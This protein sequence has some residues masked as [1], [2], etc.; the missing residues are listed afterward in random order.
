EDEAGRVK[1]AW[2]LKADEVF[3]TSYIRVFLDKVGR[4]RLIKQTGESK[5]EPDYKR[6]DQKLT[7]DVVVRFG[8]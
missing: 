4:E 5:V 6:D 7:V 3:D 2:G 1:N 8:R